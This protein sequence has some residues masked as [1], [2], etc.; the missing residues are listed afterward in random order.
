MTL[1]FR[2]GRLPAQPARPQLRLRD[3]LTAGTVPP[4]PTTADWQSRVTSWPMYLNDQIGDCTCAAVGHMIQAETTYGQGTTVTVADQDILTTY[5]KVSGYN[6][7]DPSTDQGAVIQDVLAYWQKTGIAGHKILAYASVDVGNPAE[8]RAAIDLFGSVDVGFN[9]PASAM[10]QFNAGQPWDVVKGSKIEGGHS[11]PVGA[12]AADGTLTCVTWGAVQK[13]TA[14]FWST[15]VDEAWVVI[16]QD[17]LSAKGLD[18]QGINLYQL[19]QDFAALTG[20]PNP[21]PTPQPTPSPTPAP[22]PAPASVDATLAAAVH[23]WL[24][25]KGL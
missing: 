4:A 9:F 7:A 10:T 13:L 12:Y 17:W 5:E 16:T 2:G 11:V 24:T 20:K 1:T 19:G 22:T 14:A 21:I 25:A 18:P 15:Y 8:I 3:Y 6:P 23:T